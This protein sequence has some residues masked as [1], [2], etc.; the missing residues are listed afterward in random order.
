[1]LTI[2]SLPRNLF[3]ISAINKIKKQCTRFFSQ[4]NGMPGLCLCHNNNLAFITIHLFPFYVAPT[5][6]TY[7]YFV[8]QGERVKNLKSDRSLQN[9]KS[10]FISILSYI[11]GKYNTSMRFFLRLK[12]RQ[13]NIPISIYNPKS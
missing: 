13:Y 3:Q 2:K 1:M 9:N 11:P 5:F 8:K 6:C 7:K 10:N 12:S 4:L